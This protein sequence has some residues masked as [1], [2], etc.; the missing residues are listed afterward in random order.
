[1]R[2][3]EERYPFTPMEKVLVFVLF[4]VLV[5]MSICFFRGDFKKPPVE[6]FVSSLTSSESLPS[7]DFKSV[8]KE[9]EGAEWDPED[10]DS[11]P[12]VVQSVKDVF[13][14]FADDYG[15]LTYEYIAEGALVIQP[16]DKDLQNV[17]PP[18]LFIFEEEEGKITSWKL[19]R[20]LPFSKY[21]D[22]YSG[23]WDEVYG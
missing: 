18:M 13:F 5:E 20:M 23:V 3:V 4:L 7:V 11:Y 19:A 21:S 2:D 22:E 12:H 10:H 8:F 1:M 15:D 16:R 9:L 17:N 14:S 6:T